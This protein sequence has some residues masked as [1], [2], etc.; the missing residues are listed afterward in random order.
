M[1]AMAAH[2][3]VSI[4]TYLTEAAVQ[5]RLRQLGA[6]FSGKHSTGRKFVYW[7]PHTKSW[8]AVER[9]AAGSFMLGLYSVC[10]C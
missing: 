1:A 2:S 9:G 4:E 5:A 8:G 3:P 7:I 6:S 10:P